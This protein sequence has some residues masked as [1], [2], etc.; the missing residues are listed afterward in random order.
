[1]IMQTPR[2]EDDLRDAVTRLMLFGDGKSE[3]ITEA[4]AVAFAAQGLRQY[5]SDVKE[6]KR[7]KLARAL[8]LDFERSRG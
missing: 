3:Y 7:A 2:T 4:E 6:E 8:T 1:M 5:R